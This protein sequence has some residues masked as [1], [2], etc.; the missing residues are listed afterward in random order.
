MIWGF[1]YLGWV[2]GEGIL[3]IW[4][5]GVGKGGGKRGVG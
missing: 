3:D 4:G 5:L 2:D 1:V